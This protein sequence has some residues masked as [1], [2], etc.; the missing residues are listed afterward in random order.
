MAQQG[1]NSPCTCLA[2]NCYTEKGTWHINI[3]C[4]FDKMFS[5]SLELTA[6]TQELI[7]NPLLSVKN[8]CLV[9]EQQDGPWMVLHP[10]NSEFSNHQE[11]L[12]QYSHSTQLKLWKEETYW[13]PPFSTQEQWKF[14]S[15]WFTACLVQLHYNSKYFFFY[16]TLLKA[17]VRI[18]AVQEAKMNI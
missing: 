2:R 15:V 13:V 18:R 17:S 8:I 10:N 1:R 7:L 16:L 3:K 9:S 6:L 11:F 5:P 12:H 4:A 14:S